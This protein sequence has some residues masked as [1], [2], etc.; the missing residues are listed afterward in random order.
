MII[1]RFFSVTVNQQHLQSCTQGPYQADHA[2]F[3]QSFLRVNIL[4]RLRISDTS[5]C[6]KR[7]MKFLALGLGWGLGPKR[8]LYI[9]FCFWYI[10]LSCSASERSSR[11]ISLS[12]GACFLAFRKSSLADSVWPSY[13]LAFPRLKSALTLISSSDNTWRVGLHN[14][15]INVTAVAQ[16]F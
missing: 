10:A 15:S 11:R 13:A 3:S 5:H 7:R 2:R 16:F 4:A 12:S 1:V 9:S 14:S 6:Q 8:P